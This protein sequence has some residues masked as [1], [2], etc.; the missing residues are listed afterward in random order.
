MVFT[1][2]PINSVQTLWIKH[3]FS[4][5][6]LSENNLITKPPVLPTK[7]G[8]GTKGWI[9]NDF[10]SLIKTPLIFVWMLQIASLWAGIR[11]M[12]LLLNSETQDT[13]VWNP[14]LLEAHK[15]GTP[16]PFPLFL[17]L[18]VMNSMQD[19]SGKVKT[20]NHCVHAYLPSWWSVS[21]FWSNLFSFTS[22]T[23]F[24]V[25]GRIFVTCNFQVLN[26]KKQLKGMKKLLFQRYSTWMCLQFVLSTRYYSSPPNYVVFWRCYS[27]I[28]GE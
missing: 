18:A 16:W 28:L 25:W 7:K 21:I 1:C 14:R 22:T 10:Q 19:A 20:A 8:K 2:S 24:V 15:S 26:M 27:N 11:N 5:S 23:Q 9:Y 13:E 3:T 12:S 6:K 17:Y 4:V